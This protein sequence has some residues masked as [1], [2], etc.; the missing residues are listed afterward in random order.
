MKAYDTC[1]KLVVPKAL[2]ERVADF[3]LDH[4]EEAGPFIAYPVDGHG[5]PEHMI[6][7]GEAVRGR[8]LRIKIEVLTRGDDARH[9][10]AELRLLLPGATISYWITA[11]V[12]AG[13]FL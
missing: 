3:L 8:T 5:A 10:V 7:A 11:V 1:L 13:R 6:A 2:E 12:E 9:L 4:P